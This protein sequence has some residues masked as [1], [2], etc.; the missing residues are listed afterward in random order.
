MFVRLSLAAVLSLACAQ[1][2]AF[3]FVLKGTVDHST[4]PWL[5]S[6]HV[7]TDSFADGVYSGSDLRS[8]E[9]ASD[10]FTYPG[11]L[12]YDIPPTVRLLDGQVAEITVSGFGD[13]FPTV[14]SFVVDGFTASYIVSAFKGPTIINASGTLVAVP[15][16]AT[17]A[18]FLAGLTLI[19]AVSH[20]K[21]F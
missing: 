13:A 9:F 7:E 16:P 2:I 8:F 14:T 4:S 20:R 12:T 17:F 3:D 11:G 5:G 18:L 15:E 6:L 1:A 19:G 10:L 21:R